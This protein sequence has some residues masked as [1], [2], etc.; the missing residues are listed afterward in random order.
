M[1]QAKLDALY[2]R[3]TDERTPEEER[4][5]S[6][7]LYLKHAPRWKEPTK[8]EL[9]QVFTKDIARQVLS[10]EIALL[11][12]T[13]ADAKTV[14]EKKTKLAEKAESDL[15]ELK[16]AILA[17]RTAGEKVAK[18]VD[19][20]T[21]PKTPQGDFTNQINDIFTN[22]IPHRPGGFKW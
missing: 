22:G 15:R 18:M 19:G 7:V 1:N 4:R 13:S 8:E 11:E 5:T 9:L 10:E 3:A 16:D 14:A 12:R 21:R 6:A 17:A 20:E 2:A